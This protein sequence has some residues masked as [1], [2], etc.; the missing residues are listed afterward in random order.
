MKILVLNGPNLNLLGSREKKHYGRFTL[1]QISKNLTK[2]AEQLG[3][4]LNFFQSNSE[5][6][7]VEKIQEAK[8]KFDGILVNAAAYTHTSIAIRDAFSSVEIPF[9]EVH[10][11]NLARREEFRH[12]SLLSDLA[13]GVVF[14]FGPDSYQLGLRGLVENLRN[15]R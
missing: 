9:V 4:E 1:T 14:G 5:A 11:S 10:L 8:G 13:I 3:A 12:R 2:L 15:K 6:D 7:L